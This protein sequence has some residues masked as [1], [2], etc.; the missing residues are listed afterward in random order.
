MLA[1]TRRRLGGSLSRQPPSGG[2]KCF[3]AIY[4]RVGHFFLG[5]E[6]FD[7]TPTLDEF[8]FRAAVVDPL[9]VRTSDFRIIF[10]QRVLL[11]GK[12]ADD[13]IGR[14]GLPYTHNSKKLDHVN[15][16]APRVLVIKPWLK[17]PDLSCLAADLLFRNTQLGFGDLPE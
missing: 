8:Q 10:V 11:V 16:L 9:A 1:M 7:F 14:R 12:L 13:P 17:S 2:L 5:Q 15:T 3:V 4:G 6:V